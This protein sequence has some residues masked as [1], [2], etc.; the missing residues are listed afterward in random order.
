M[1]VYPTNKH[2]SD[3]ELIS[4]DFP[5][6]LSLNE[7]RRAFPAHRHDFLECSLVIEG[8]GL[9]K[10]NGETHPMRRGT[11]TLLLPYQIHEIVTTSSESLR[12][13]NCMFAMDLLVPS[14]DPGSRR[15]LDGVTGNRLPFHQFEESSLPP[16]V[17]L[18]EE[19][20]RE[21]RERRLLSR[22]YVT[23]KLHETLIRFLR[24][25]ERQKPPDPK[26]ELS[27]KGGYAWSI[28]E[29]IHGHY[30]EDMALSDLSARFSL[31][32]SRVSAAIKRHTGTSFVQLLHEIRLRHACGLLAA[33]DMSMLEIA[34]E[35]GFRSYKGFARVFRESKGL[36]P[37]EYRKRRLQQS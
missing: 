14:A 33:T 36:S 4:P 32:P 2:L 21:S 18:F 7:I 30:R 13:Y 31:H 11:F 22:E 24:A 1:T 10:I 6:H 35:V 5:F 12:L 29:Y 15:L 9:E 20:L 8:E 19:M 27:G 17:H 3:Y 26:S 25:G 16:L 28:I 37:G 34:L 23:L